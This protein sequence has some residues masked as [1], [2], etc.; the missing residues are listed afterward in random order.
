[1]NQ[2]PDWGMTVLNGGEWKSGRGLSMAGLYVGS[3]KDA[4]ICMYEVYARWTLQ[5]VCH[6]LRN[7]TCTP[8]SSETSWGENL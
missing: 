4:R 5:T 6:T 8:H 7:Q 3:L 1:M 2:G